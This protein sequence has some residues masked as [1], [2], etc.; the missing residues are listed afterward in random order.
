M[1]VKPNG[2]D[3]KDVALYFIRTTSGRATPAII[4]RTVVQA[5]T[6]LQSGYTKAEILDVIDVVI[7]KGIEIYSLGYISTCIN[8][9]LRELREAKRVE[10]KKILS[11]QLKEEIASQQEQQSEVS[12]DGEST[13]RN[14]EKL[15][16][17]GNESRFGKKF[18]FDMFEGQ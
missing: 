18:N 6:L 9:V 11:A 8:D 3:A 17:F 10:E 5:K 7:D 1:T 12:N 4:S 15:D 13:D 14:R 16:R 2:T